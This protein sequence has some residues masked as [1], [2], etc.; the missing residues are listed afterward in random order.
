MSDEERVRNPHPGDIIRHDFLE[1][2]GMTPYRLAKGLGIT[3]SAAAELVNGKRNVTAV[4]ALRLAAFLGCSP[5]F[6]MGLQAAYDLEEVERNPA[7]A[8]KIAGLTRYQPAEKA[9][10]APG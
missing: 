10:S 3:P 6:W 9:E 5:R 4:T 8:A 1:P 7:L 2:W